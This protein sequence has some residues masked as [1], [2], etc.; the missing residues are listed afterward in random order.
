MRF[1]AVL[2]SAQLLALGASAET[3]SDRAVSILNEVC[4]AQT[5]SEARMAAAEKKAAAESW[6]LV[7]SGPA[8]MAFM[9]NEN[10]PKVAFMSSWKLDGSQFYIS[11]LRPD[12]RPDLSS[13]VRGWKYDVCMVQPDADVDG[14]EL[15]DAINREFKSAVVEDKP[16]GDSQTWFFG[17]DKAGGNC[18][19]KLVVLLHQQSDRGKPKTLIFSDLE[20]PNDP[21]WNTAR[22]LVTGCPNH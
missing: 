18:G 7:K 22:N 13:E 6:Q 20:Y 21:R 5:A 12:Q 19:K 8:P 16:R 2:V 15:A 17:E 9:H 4:V 10:G 1:G 3:Q 14:D 11:I